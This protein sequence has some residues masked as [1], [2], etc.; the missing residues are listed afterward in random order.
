MVKIARF[1][2][3]GTCCGQKN[4][5]FSLDECV[6]VKIIRFS[7]AYMF[8]DQNHKFK[9]GWNVLTISVSAWR[10]CVMVKIAS[11]SLTGICCG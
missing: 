1:S 2:K 3:T 9:H 10:V 5:F 6:V 4:H 8:L 11:F 7:M